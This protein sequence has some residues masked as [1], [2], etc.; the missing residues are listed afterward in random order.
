[1]R[2]RGQI[3]PSL[4]ALAGVF[5]GDPLGNDPNNLSGTNFNLR[6][7]TLWISELQYAINQPSEGELVSADS[8]GLPG[9]YKIG[10]W[11]NNNHFADQHLDTNGTTTPAFRSRIRPRPALRRHIAAI[12][13]STR[14]P[15]R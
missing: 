15:T 4:T 1:M 8:R 10:F 12:T 2:V 6:N 13:A 3:T 7:G 5:A 14:W 9:T 11:Y